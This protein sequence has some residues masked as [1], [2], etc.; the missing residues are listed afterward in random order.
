MI[1][2]YIVSSIEEYLKQIFI[3]NGLGLPYESE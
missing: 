1:R 3:E 2:K